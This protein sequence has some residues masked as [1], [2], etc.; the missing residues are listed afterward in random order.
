MTIVKGPPMKTITR[1]H[2][3]F[4]F[5]PAFE[6]AETA[7]PGETVRFLTKD[8]YDGQIDRDGKDFAE[9]DMTR[10]NPVTGPLFVKGAEPGDILKVDILSV[11]P[12]DHGVMCVRP[13][14]GIYEVQGSCC[15]R[16]EIKDGLIRFDGGRN[17]PLRMMI[18][19]IGTTPA[20]PRDTQTPGEHGGN[21]DIKDLGAGCSVCL[22]VYVPGALLAL[23]DCHAVQGD[24]ETAICAMEAA[25]EVTVRVS[26]IRGETELPTP[27]IETEDHIYTT[28][29]DESLDAASVAAAGKM[30]RYLMKKSGLSDA[31]AAMLLSLAGDL[32]ISQV[33]NPKKGCVMQFPKRY[34]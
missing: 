23:G 1:E 15:R 32:R 16:F 28:F 3:H 8:C 13:G 29:G 11:V 27:F 5:D 7:E 31:Q 18:G 17:I 4:R 20:E 33:V 12:E 26:V 19:V 34:L 9:L 2:I 10:N 21:L 25:A 14:K 30:H 24:G 22:P 6:P